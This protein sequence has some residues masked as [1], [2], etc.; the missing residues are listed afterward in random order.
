[1]SFDL[2]FQTV[3]V[4]TTTRFKG[5]PLAIVTIPPPPHAQPT[6]EQKQSIAR[7]F[8]LS[9]TVFLHDIP[10]AEKATNKSRKF[11][12]FLTNRE[13]PFAGHPTV[14]TAVSL[15]GEGVD[16]LVAKA[17]ELKVQKIGDGNTVK[18]QIPHDLHL[19][20]KRLK[21]LVGKLDLTLSSNET[22][23]R[24]ELEAPVFSIVNG[25]TFVLVELPDLETLGK[26][27]YGPVPEE[28]LTDEGWRGGFAAKYYYVRQGSAY[29]DPEDGMT[30]LTL[31][32]RMLEG[33]IED[34]ATGS[35]ASC[36]CSYLGLTE[37]TGKSQ[38]FKYQVIQGVE[39]GRESTIR[40]E[41]DVKD[42]KVE[43]VF[44]AGTAVQVQRGVFTVL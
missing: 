23:R 10:E 32:S 5:N 38:K 9:E 41:V 7:E 30:A 18:V 15:L 39:M 43:T 16:T 11:D 14:G 29:E 8:N 12:I 1:M 26:V 17:G 25:M 44:L 4:F 19:H 37:G 2:P 3:D 22:I 27:H 42:E 20:Q 28:H 31:R 36:L 33:A 35:A 13:I 40:I 24:A 34:P 21:D 6:Q